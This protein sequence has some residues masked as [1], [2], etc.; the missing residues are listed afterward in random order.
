MKKLSIVLFGLLLMTVTNVHS[1]SLK[2]VKTSCD[3]QLRTKSFR[4]LQTI[5]TYE[6]YIA[7][8][9]DVEGNPFLIATAKEIKSEFE[10]FREVCENF[11]NK[12]FKSKQEIRDICAQLLDVYEKLEYKDLAFL[13]RLTDYLYSL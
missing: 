12:E 10:K 9:E 8:L 11:Y 13:K 1:A 6:T 5:R 7:T 4:A 2:D 3:L